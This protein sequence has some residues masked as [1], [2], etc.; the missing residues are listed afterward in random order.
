MFLLCLLFSVF[1]TVEQCGFLL[2]VFCVL[3]RLKRVAFPPISH[4]KGLIWGFFAL[5]VGGAVPTREVSSYDLLVLLFYCDATK[6]LIFLL[7]V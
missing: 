2:E 6:D 4:D 1:F 7:I 3:V 5:R